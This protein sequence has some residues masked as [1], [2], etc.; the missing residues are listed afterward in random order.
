MGNKAKRSKIYDRVR[1]DQ[2]KGWTKY[3]IEPPIEDPLIE[4]EEDSIEV[5]ESTRTLG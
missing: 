5:S 1:D 4:V 2:K 3:N